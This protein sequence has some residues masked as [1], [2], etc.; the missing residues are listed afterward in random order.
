MFINTNIIIIIIIVIII[1]SHQS[2]VINHQSSII[3]DQSSVI[4]HQW[5][6]ISHQLA[7]ITFIKYQAI[8]P[9]DIIQNVTTV[10]SLPETRHQNHVGSPAMMGSGHDRV[11]W[12]GHDNSVWKWRIYGGIYHQKKPFEW[13]NGNHQMCYM[14]LSDLQTNPHETTVF[15]AKHRWNG[16]P[17]A[18]GQLGEGSLCFKFPNFE[19]SPRSFTTG[20][21]FPST[22]AYTTHGAR[23]F[24]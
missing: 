15:F 24:T 21:W 10:A 3:S 13:E 4:N 19:L 16:P 17:I 22:N 20:G 9:L 7:I 1:I 6:I 2:S 23:I 5:S 11:P 12:L 8:P 14:L 18:P